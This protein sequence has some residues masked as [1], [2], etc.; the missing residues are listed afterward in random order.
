M[1]MGE[2]D[3]FDGADL[4]QI[5]GAFDHNGVDEEDVKYMLVEAKK[6]ADVGVLR[7]PEGTR[8]LNFKVL[9]SYMGPGFLMSLAYLDPGNLEADLQSGAYAGYQLLWMLLWATLAGLVLQI[10]AARLGVVTGLN[11]AE[12]CRLEY[13]KK[14]RIMLWI[15]TEIAIIGSDIQEVRQGGRRKRGS[16]GRFG[17]TQRWT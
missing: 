2:D 9:W 13:G 17:K 3:D 6:R 5:A 14:T 16:V 1:A 15:M 8:C 7:E 4:P 11:L 10:L 12:I